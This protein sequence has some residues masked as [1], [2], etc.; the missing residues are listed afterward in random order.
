MEQ[1]TW[2]QAT[3]A[4]AFHFG[5]MGLSATLL[6]AWLAASGGAIDALRDENGST[7]LLLISH[8]G[9]R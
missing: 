8:R 1:P 6:E 3:I 5:V 9:R 4:M 2:W 7:H